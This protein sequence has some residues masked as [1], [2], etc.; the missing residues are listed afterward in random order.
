MRIA[1]YKIISDD[2]NRPKVFISSNNKSYYPEE[3]AA[4]I[5]RHLTKIAKNL[6]N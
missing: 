6:L 3:I 5:L 2:N 1:P 4:I